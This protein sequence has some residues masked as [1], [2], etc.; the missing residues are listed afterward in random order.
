M[1]FKKIHHIAIMCS[2]YTKSKDIYV[3]KP[4]LDIKQENVQGRKRLLQARPHVERRIYHRTVLI[5]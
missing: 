3:N 2:D 1:N 4:G 5:P